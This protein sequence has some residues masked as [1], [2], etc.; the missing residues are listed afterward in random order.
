[1]V[2]SSG[3]KP[4]FRVSQIDPFFNNYCQSTGSFSLLCLFLNIVDKIDKMT[5]KECLGYAFTTDVAKINNYQWQEISIRFSAGEKMSVPSCPVRLR[6]FF[7]TKICAFLKKVTIWWQ[8]NSMPW[9]LVCTKWLNANICRV[10][11]NINVLDQSYTVDRL[12]RIRC[13]WRK[14]PVTDL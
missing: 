6:N 9:K 10:K 11:S 14:K 12:L 1:M 13:Y 4:L 3:Y 5:H 7:A 2:T 8:E